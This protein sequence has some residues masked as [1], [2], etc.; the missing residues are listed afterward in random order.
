MH[1]PVLFTLSAVGGAAVPNNRTELPTLRTTRVA[2][3]PPAGAAVVATS[4]EPEFLV[5]DHAARE[6]VVTNPLGAAKALGLAWFLLWWLWLRSRLW[7][8]HGLWLRL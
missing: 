6:L 1:T 2:D 8:W 4:E 3:Q 7:L 5:A